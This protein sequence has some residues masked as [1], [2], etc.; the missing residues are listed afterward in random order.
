[1]SHPTQ[2]WPPTALQSSGPLARLQVRTDQTVVLLRC[3]S[4]WEALASAACLFA[5]RVI[6]SSSV[7]YGLSM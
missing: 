4:S 2:S 3:F 5:Q 6:V 7:T 1:M